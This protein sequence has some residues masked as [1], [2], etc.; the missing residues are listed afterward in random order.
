MLLSHLIKS[1][2]IHFLF[3][4]T[5]KANSVLVNSKNELFRSIPSPE[6]TRIPSKYTEKQNGI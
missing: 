6:S 5:L 1:R 3:I 4:S 2:V